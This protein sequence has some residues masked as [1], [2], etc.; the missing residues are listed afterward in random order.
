MYGGGS[1]ASKKGQEDGDKW[2]TAHRKLVG[3]AKC[4][5]NFE[6]N[7]GSSGPVERVTGEFVWSD[8]L[9]AWWCDTTLQAQLW[10]TVKVAWHD[11]HEGRSKQSDS[12]EIFTSIGKRCVAWQNGTE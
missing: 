9:E 3:H 6:N 12:N 5:G 7:H 11:V 10:T 4:A 2:L 8:E 1:K